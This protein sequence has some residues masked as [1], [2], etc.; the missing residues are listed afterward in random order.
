M[1]DG[2]IE[3]AP[4]VV[5]NL[6]DRD[7]ALESDDYLGTCMINLKDAS[8]NEW[9]LSNFNAEAKESANIIPKPRWHDIHF[10]FD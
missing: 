6:W 2:E 4:P 9:D 10:G 5:F 7:G 1:E 3:N 8:I